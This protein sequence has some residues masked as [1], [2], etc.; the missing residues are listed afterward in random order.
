M[1]DRFGLLCSYCKQGAPHPSPQELDWSS[2]DWD[3]TKAKA[4]EQTNSLMGYNTP[5]PHTDIEQT[6]DVNEIAF[7]KLQIGQSDLKEEKLEVTD[8]LIPPPLTEMPEDMVRKE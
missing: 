7:S 4:R 6:T 5:R 1:C 3:G 2:E 8:S